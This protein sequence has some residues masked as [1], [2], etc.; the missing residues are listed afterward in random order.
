MDVAVGLSGGVDS[1][2]SALLL[3]EQGHH[4]TGITM[5]LWKG[6]YRGG[7]KRA[8]FGAGEEKNIE[9]AARI[10]RTIGIRHEIFDCSEEYDK[11]VIEPFRKTWLDGKTPNPC[12]ICNPIIKFGLLVRLA[13][14]SG[15][16]MDRFATGHYARISRTS[17]GRYAIKRA[18]DKAKDQSYFLYRLG[19]EQIGRHI[20]PLGG[21]TKSQV[22]EMAKKHS[23]PAADRPDS[24]DF[25]SGEIEELLGL[26]PREGFVVDSK[27]KVLGKHNGFWNF[28]IGQRKGLGIGGLKEP[29]YVIAVDGE[30][31]EVTIGTAEETLC[32]EFGIKS[33]CHQALAREDLLKGR[34]E[35]LVKVRSTG[36]PRFP[37]YVEEDR[38]FLPEGLSSVAPGQSAVFY[39]GEGEILLGGIIR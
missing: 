19:Q 5:R 2:L 30:K 9:D 20:F 12:V 22:R 13:K 37:A 29:Y 36:E 15:L 17:N 11:S 8:C 4:V 34:C 35:C 1:A 39:N 24:Q 7:D 6:R 38:C 16:S 23:L 31:N 26:E 21:F 33:V 14:E 28:T 25:Y 10:A 18:A 27:G 32:R 3:K